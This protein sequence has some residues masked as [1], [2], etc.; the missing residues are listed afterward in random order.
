MFWRTFD[1]QISNI[2]FINKTKKSYLYELKYKFYQ[3]KE[4]FI[5]AVKQKTLTEWLYPEGQGQG[6]GVK[7]ICYPLE[8]QGAGGKERTEP[9]KKHRNR[10]SSETKQEKE[11]GPK[12]TLMDFIRGPKGQGQGTGPQN[13]ISEGEQKKRAETLEAIHR[14]TVL[15]PEQSVV[16]QQQS[17]SKEEKQNEK[18]HSALRE[19]GKKIGIVGAVISA[20]G[21]ALFL[22]GFYYLPLAAFGLVGMSL[23]ILGVP[24]LFVGGV[25]WVAGVINE[26]EHNDHISEA[27]KEH[28]VRA[29]TRIAGEI[30]EGI[31]KLAHRV[32]K[33][34]NKE[35]KEQKEEFIFTP[36]LSTPTS[37]KRETGQTPI[38]TPVVVN[39]QQR[40]NGTQH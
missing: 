33:A 14:T 40:L 2:P 23:A 4:V 24:L 16:K 34:L 18:Y 11:Q 38:P 8:E 26:A 28:L 19:N 36:L 12:I 21:A 27:I 10:A 32:S 1:V 13:T 17:V 35:K 29:F 25:T 15:Q 30:D 3:N 37:Q 31:H 22:G 7:M 5:M 6:A 20:L 39:K 9:K